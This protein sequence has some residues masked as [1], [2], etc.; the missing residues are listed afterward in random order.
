MQWFER[1]YRAMPRYPDEAFEATQEISLGETPYG[2]V[3]KVMGYR[4]DADEV[5]YTYG[6]DR[7][8]EINGYHYERKGE[9]FFEILQIFGGGRDRMAKITKFS[10][11]FQTLEQDCASQG[12][13]ALTTI[14][15]P[16]LANAACVRYGFKPS[17]RSEE[18]QIRDFDRRS[19]YTPPSISLFKVI[20]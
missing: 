19:I 5:I 9:K 14:C 7:N 10:Q 16:N 17:G 11:L 4:G 8:I 15:I 12:I 2:E 6:E 18:R 20:R 13:R 1:R 3:V